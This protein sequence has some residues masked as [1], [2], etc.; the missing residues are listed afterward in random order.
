MSVDP[1][2]AVVATPSYVYALGQID[3]RFPSLA[4]D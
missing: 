4:V 3:L 1:N 2:G